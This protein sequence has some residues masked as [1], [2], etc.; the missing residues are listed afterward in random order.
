MKGRCLQSFFG[1]N[2]SGNIGEIIDVPDQATF[3]ELVQSGYL[4][5]VDSPTQ[6]ENVS[7]D[8]ETLAV[9]G[10]AKK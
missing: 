5:A 10:R 7:A 8:P 6:N 1:T 3:D 9:K 2:V 4:E